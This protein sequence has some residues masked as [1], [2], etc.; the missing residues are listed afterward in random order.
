MQ[1]AEPAEIQVL[2]DPS[3]FLPAEKG[4]T[5]LGV[6]SPA[7]QASSAKWNFFIESWN[8]NQ[9][10]SKHTVLTVVFSMRVHITI[11]IMIWRPQVV[12]VGSSIS[13]A[14][15]NQQHLLE[16]LRAAQFPG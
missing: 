7:S 9:N 15:C 5:G 4:A 13:P 6:H 2:D 12:S 1:P 11:C 8:Y 14:D 3:L 16:Q 10:P